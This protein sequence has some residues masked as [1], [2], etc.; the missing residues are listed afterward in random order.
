MSL[1]TPWC[2]INAWIASA[3]PDSSIHQNM[4]TTSRLTITKHP[5]TAQ[6]NRYQ[7]S[8]SVNPSKMI[9]SQ[10]RRPGKTDHPCV[11]IKVTSNVHFM[12]NEGVPCVG[13]CLA[14][15]RMTCTQYPLTIRLRTK[16][17]V[18]GYINVHVSNDHVYCDCSARIHVSV[19]VNDSFPFHTM[20]D[21]GKFGR[22]F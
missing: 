3:W 9:S 13:F 10:L 12:E 5:S 14:L 21:L 11:K 17:N 1:G 20:L 22:N 19:S 6:F 2:S 16:W 18:L 7:H 8:K 4:S 15:P